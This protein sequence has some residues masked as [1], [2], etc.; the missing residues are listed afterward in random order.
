V[1]RANIAFH[2]ETRAIPEKHSLYACET[3]NKLLDASGDAGFNS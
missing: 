1:V 3:T 2:R